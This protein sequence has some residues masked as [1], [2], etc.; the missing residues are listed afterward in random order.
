M[1]PDR[2][3]QIEKLYHAAREH[4]ADRRAAFLERAC[5]GDESLRHEVEALL[6]EDTGA[7]NF[8]ET[9][10]LDVV[11][12]E[13]DPSRDPRQAGAGR[14]RADIEDEPGQSLIGR[15]LGCYEILSLLGK[16]G[17]GEVYRARDTKLGREVALKVLPKAFARD[18]ERLARFRREARLLASLNHE[19]IAAIYG[20]EESEGRHFLVMELVPG[21]DLRD[22]I[23]RE[24]AVPLEESLKIASQIAE[25]LEHAHEKN[26]I[27]RDLKPANV[28]ITA[29]GKVK[30]LDFGLA[31]AFEAEGVDVDLS[32]TPATAP[33][34]SA[35]RSEEGRILGT[36]AYMSP[37][38]ARGKAVDKRTD[39]WAFGC[40]LYELLTG[41]QAFTGENVTDMLA[42]V[43]HQEPDWTQLPPT[44]AQSVRVLLRRCLQKDAKR[45]LQHIGDARIEI[46]EAPSAP[47]VISGVTTPAPAA[48]QRKLRESVAWAAAAI[49]L[50]AA[51]ALAALYIRRAPAEVRPLR[52]T[53]SPPEKAAFV[54]APQILTVSPDG[55]RLAFQAAGASGRRML[56]V[57]SLDSL[58]AQPL[59]GT[60][61]AQQPFWSA[62]SRSIAFYAEGTLKKIDVSG[63]PPQT[64]TGLEGDVGASGSWSRD[65]VILFTK[66][67]ASQILRV[68]AAGGTATA[69]TALDASREQTAHLWPCFLPD[70]RHFV[71]LAQSAKVEN[72]GIYVGSVDSKD[73][74]LLLNANSMAEYSPPGYLL[75]QREGNLMAQPF[76]ASRLELTGDAF[77]IAEGVL[78]NPANGRAAFGVSENGVLAYRAGG[79]TG[80]QLA[81]M[82]RAGQEIARFGETSG[83]GI[84][85][86]SLSPDERRVAIDLRT[87]Q[88]RDLWLIDILRGTTSRFALGIVSPGLVWSFDGT[89]LTYAASRAG[90][91][92]LYR[93]LSSGAG[94]EE[95]LLNEPGGEPT[96]L[97]RDGRF[98]IYQRS[99]RQTQ[100]DLWVLPLFGDPGPAGVVARKPR[101]FLQ[102]V[103][104]EGQGQF[105]PDGRWVAYSSDETGRLEIYVQPFPGP[106]PKVQISTAGGIMP[107][108]RGDG[109]ELFYLA[110]GALMSVEIK[111]GAQ[112]EAGVPVLLFNAQVGQ[113]HGIVPGKD[114][115]V[116]ADGKRFLILKPKEGDSGA[117]IT[118]VL[119]W[120][121]ELRRKVPGPK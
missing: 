67:S 30:A 102:T 26:I 38:Q 54:S 59:A 109:K 79:I 27:H 94:Q 95:L 11:A 62:D 24:G 105:S 111:A 76:D 17:M 85:H 114:Y 47:P 112:I 101:P 121:D 2:G 34:I 33:T 83:R 86:F 115:D 97:S 72:T 53:I 70:G 104:N 92:G 13:L 63:G 91:A 90:A 10:A 81:W 108:W 12:K 9:P 61:E 119:N 56:W 110:G 116:S 3:E 6:A 39:I 44:T 35:V 57:R 28:K 84:A 82:D 88:G 5:A 8:L 42:A 75:F 23:I 71:F 120:F 45:R 96:D 18:R 32:A 117:P 87:A 64:I 20:L 55:K 50:L 99:D 74:K 98:L 77:P 41:K 36:P 31:K 65:G 103:F 4:E 21:E 66:G 7:E 40:V 93:K 107:K 14:E 69:V 22:R 60:E 78:F 68:S 37:E 52:F 19:N 58:S 80:S 29:Q 51:A 48:A 43:L 46:E 118:V 16:G 100:Y 73:S 113:A 106:G 25:A 89:S 1:T 49:G 15:M